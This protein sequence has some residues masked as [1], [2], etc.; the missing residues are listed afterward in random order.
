MRIHSNNLVKNFIPIAFET[1]EP[2]V[3][4][5][6]GRPNKNNNKNNYSNTFKMSRDMGSVP[7]RIAILLW[8]V[9]TGASHRSRR[10]R[11]VCQKLANFDDNFDNRY[12]KIKG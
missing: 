3:F 1:T 8:L 10:R 9:H 4:F 7:D 6:S 12:H 2:Y 5:G 11:N